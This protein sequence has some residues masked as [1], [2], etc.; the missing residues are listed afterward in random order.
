MGFEP[1]TTCLGSKDS[2]TELR[3]PL[4]IRRWN[5]TLEPALSQGERLIRLPRVVC[6][7][8]LTAADT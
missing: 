8:E 5:P 3:P 4:A 2:T 7:G 6:H 1:T